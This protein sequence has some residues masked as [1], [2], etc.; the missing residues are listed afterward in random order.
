MPNIKSIDTI[1]KLYNFTDEDIITFNYIT[2]IINNFHK[3]NIPKITVDNYLEISLQNLYLWLFYFGYLN[4]NNSL[5]MYSKMLIRYN[6]IKWDDYIPNTINF[7][8]SKKLITQNIN[9]L[10]EAVVS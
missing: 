1:F 3:I 7:N 4:R 2:E 8:E 9:E 10:K 6:T 5:E